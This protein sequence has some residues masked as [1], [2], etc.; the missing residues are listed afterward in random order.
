MALERVSEPAPPPLA[1]PASG[2]K[3]LGRSSR[4]I[5]SSAVLLSL[6]RSLW[7]PELHAVTLCHRLRLASVLEEGCG[8]TGALT[9]RAE[10]PSG[11]QRQMGSWSWE[12][13]ATSPQPCADK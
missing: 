10:K 6:L 11:P 1:W 12:P 3:V 4:A 8:G 13:G 5:P 9:L 7:Q 2:Q